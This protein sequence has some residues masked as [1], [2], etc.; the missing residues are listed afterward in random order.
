MRLLY[1]MDPMCAWCFGFKPELE[2]F[3]ANH[4][5][6]EVEWVMGGLAPDTDV[7]MDDAL[8][9]TIAAYWHQIE[10]KTQVTFNHDYW[11]TNTPYRS[12][13]PA[14]RAVIAAERLH[15]GSA[16]KM[17]QAI[18]SAYYLNAQNP[19]LENT[20]IDCASSIGLDAHPFL[21]E[22]HSQETEQHFQQHLGIVYQLQISGFPALIYIDNENRA[23]PLTLGYCQTTDLEARLTHIQR[24]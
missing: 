5:S 1:I 24:L 21:T 18:Q 6:A 23:H 13:Y 22:L 11:H 8:K 3:L 2:S 19:S 17:A 16:P 15:Q 12:T 9:R 7:P 10:D 4:P 20:L 14:C